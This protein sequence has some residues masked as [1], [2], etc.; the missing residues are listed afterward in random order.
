MKTDNR[1]KARSDK[2]WLSAEECHLEDFRSL[3]ERTT[4]RADYPFASEVAANVRSYDG[5][6]VRRAAA[7]PDSRRAL[8]AEWVDAMTDGPGIVVFRGAFADCTALDAAS[9]QFRAM[10]DEQHAGN[11]GGGDHFAKPGANDRVWNAL[12]KLCLRAP[13]VFAAYYG[14]E[15]IALI[16]GLGPAA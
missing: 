11:T 14:N 6:A 13:E 1:T 8:L 15:V 2:V 12:E 5:A 9:E 4:D 16:T 10:I 3:V 7:S